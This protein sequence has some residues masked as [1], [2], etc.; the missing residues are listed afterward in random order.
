MIGRAI[1]LPALLALIGAAAFVAAGRRSPDA[2]GPQ[3]RP[4]AATHP[5][6]V[7]L[8]TSQGCSSCP[9]ADAALARFAQDPNV[10]AISRPVTY[11]DS[12]GWRDTLARPANTELQRAYAARQQSSDVY[13]PQAIVQGVVALVGGRTGAIHRAIDEAALRPAPALDV[14]NAAGGRVLTLN[15]AAQ[16]PAEI[17]LLALRARVPVA[18]GR[19]ENGGHVVDYVNVVIAENVIGAW[20]GGRL[21]LPLPAARL[22]VPGA[23][24][25]AIIVQEPN[26]GPILTAAYL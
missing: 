12:L 13:T 10:V 9:P 15:G 22:L 21:R 11:W 19:G 7:E 2:P 17:H 4:S 6:V 20:R 3:P 18:I 26:A 25:Y 14:E 8:F 5:V 24:R 1:L 23:D 16:R